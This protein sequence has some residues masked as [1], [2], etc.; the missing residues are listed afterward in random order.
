MV[1]LGQKSEKFRKISES[2]VRQF[3][4]I[5]GDYNPIHLDEEVASKS[6]F[7]KR[8]VHGM[9]GAS[10]ISS[11]ISNDLPGE[12]SIYISQNLNFIRPIYVGDTVLTSVEVIGAHGR[13]IVLKTICSVGGK[14][15]ID[16]EAVVSV[17]ED[18]HED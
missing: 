4:K 10:L 18:L 14:T 9:F 8:I 2:D 11:V 5:S 13:R 16:G 12:G 7:G 3:S 17:L 6:F 15:V 1:K